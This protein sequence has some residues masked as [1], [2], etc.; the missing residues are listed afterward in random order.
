MAR[1]EQTAEPKLAQRLHSER[2]VIGSSCA[3]G[4][5]LGALL[6]LVQP[7]DFW[8][9]DHAA[10]WQALA[11]YHAEL[12]QDVRCQVTEWEKLIPPLLTTLGEQAQTKTLQAIVNQGCSHAAI[13]EHEARRLATLAAQ[14]RYQA[15]IAGLTKRMHEE[16]DQHTRALIANAIRSVPL[17]EDPGKRETL[18]TQVDAVMGA[19][20]SGESPSP[21]ILPTGLQVFDNSN[22]MGLHPG[23]LYVVAGRPGWGKSSIIVQWVAAACRAGRPTAL[24]SMEMSEV[25][26]V[27]RFAGLLSGV[28]VMDRN[29]DRF[30]FTDDERWHLQEATAEIRGW[31]LHLRC[32]PTSATQLTG[33][34]SDLQQ[35]HGVQIVAVDYLQ[36]I[37]GTRGQSTL[38]RITEASRQCK[39]LSLQGVAV[40]VAAQLNREALAGPRPRA[41]NLAG[42]DQIAADADSVICPWR[43][44][45]SG[46]PYGYAELLVLKGRRCVVGRHRMQW[47]GSVQTY[48]DGNDDYLLPIDDDEPK[49]KE[50]GR[51]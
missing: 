17:P 25:D 39:L 27:L 22:G 48:V 21:W 26:I 42:C 14:D 11:T 28:H 35:R 10:I 38:D 47:V 49:Q 18:T 20:L 9:P 30:P 12:P 5:V 33:W 32:Q 51:W 37:L 3:D 44:G 41:E 23:R 7:R 16:A 6:P 2:I 1:K 4:N 36:Q 29:Q 13:A 24:L 46:A 19:L 50:R 40:V 45:G 8:D 43:G 34:A 31:P 15:E